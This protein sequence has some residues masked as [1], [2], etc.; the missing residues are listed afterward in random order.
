MVGA[1]TQSFRNAAA[2]WIMPRDNCVRVFT[3]V[4]NEPF[5]LNGFP[6]NFDFLQPKCLNV[7]ALQAMRS[8]QTQPKSGNHGLSSFVASCG[9]ARCFARYTSIVLAAPF[10]NR[11]C[12]TAVRIAGPYPIHRSAFGSQSLGHASCN[13]QGSAVWQA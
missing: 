9:F 3:H 7:K 5:F 12:N 4:T 10:P 6:S 1:T 2:K 8:H 13:Y 11:H